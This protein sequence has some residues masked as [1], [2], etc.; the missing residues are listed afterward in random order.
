MTAPIGKATAVATATGATLPFTGLPT[1]WMAL[2]AASLVT[3]GAILM[4]L[5]PRRER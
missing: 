5:V 4:K 3:A 2:A 1:A